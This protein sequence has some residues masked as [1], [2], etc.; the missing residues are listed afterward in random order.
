MEQNARTER[1]KAK[2]DTGKRAQE[3]VDALKAA[4]QVGE[5]ELTRDRRIRAERAAAAGHVIISHQ[6]LAYAQR[7][8]EGLLEDF[9]NRHP[10]LMPNLGSPRGGSVHG[11]RIEEMRQEIIK[12][13]LQAINYKRAGHAEES[14]A[15][16]PDGRWARRYYANAR[17][18]L[19]WLI[20][21]APSDDPIEMD[22]AD[23]LPGSGWEVSYD[24]PW[25]VVL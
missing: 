5:C 22:D 18:R 16:H 20:G 9:S 2:T 6:E 24:A 17:K 13:I 7:Q 21:S 4:T 1:A 8:L 11:A 23:N 3:A 25:R 14:L 10:E 15:R 12:T 19:V